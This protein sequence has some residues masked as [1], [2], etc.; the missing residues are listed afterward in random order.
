MPKAPYSDLSARHCEACEGGVEKLDAQSV[1]EQ[2]RQ[3]PGW[4]G[5]P[6]A[7][8]KEFRF[9]DHYQTMAFVNAVAWISHR[10]NHHPDIAVGYDKANVKYSTHAADG[11][12]PNDLICAA[13]IE[14]LMA[15]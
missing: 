1:A 3:L 4:S 11:V 13:K 8:H 9:K 2:L 10:E 6:R 5:D 7:I 15:L 14:T 12:T